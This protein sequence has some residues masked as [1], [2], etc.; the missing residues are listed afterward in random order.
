VT[1]AWDLPDLAARRLGGMVLAANDEFFAPKERLLEPAAPVFEPGRYTDRGKWMDG[2]ETRRRREPGHDWCVVRLG[3]PGV[4]HGVVVDTAHFKGNQ[5]EACSVDGLAASGDAAVLADPGAGVAGPGVAGSRPA[6]PGAAGP[7]AGGWFELVPRTGLRPDAE[8]RLPVAAPVRVTHV[9][10]NI[11]PDGGV[12]RL[13]VHGEPLPDLRLLA[14]PAG[15]LDLAAATSGGEAIDCSDMFFSSRHNLVMPG[16]AAVMGEGWETRRRRGPGHDWVVV[17]LA[18][19]AAIE[20]VEV[21]TTHFKG[22]HP[23]SCEVEACSAPAAGRWAAP[24]EGWWTVVPRS[25]LGPHARHVFPVAGGRPTTHVR[26]DI[27]P[28]G[29]VSRL[30]VVGRVTDDG[31]RRWG[32]GWL[33]ALPALQAEAELLACCA[34]RAWAAQLAAARPF[35]DPEALAKSA[36]EVWA[37]LGPDDWLEAFAAHPRIGERLAEPAEAAGQAPAPAGPGGAAGPAP[38]SATPAKASGSAPASAAA[39][40]APASGWSAREQAGVAGADQATLAELAAGNREYEERFGH[41]FLIFA[42][43]RSAAEMLAALRERLG[44]DPA[45][46]LRVAA[47]EQRKITRLRLEKLFRPPEGA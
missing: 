8:H 37:G 47:E 11:H 23:E 5:P 34:S 2:W 36:D 33:D 41:V 22:N 17:R 25:R 38:A 18:A 45:A 4:V 20:R 42:S 30:R 40:S 10:L 26:L 6:E 7:G 46:E 28:D 9:R 35:G 12:A 31:W 44:N 27:H 16:D 19:E 15:G 29:G 32:V 24:A 14:G 21:A 43:G 3:V 1:D 39:P 13:R